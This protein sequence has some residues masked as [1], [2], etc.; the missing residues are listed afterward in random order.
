MSF[1]GYDKIFRIFIPEKKSDYECLE[2]NMAK[3]YFQNFDLQKE[4][5]CLETEICKILAFK[6]LS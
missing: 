2:A 4:V 1:K 6:S 3:F 5:R